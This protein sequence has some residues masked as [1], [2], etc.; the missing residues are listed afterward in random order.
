MSPRAIDGRSSFYTLAPHSSSTLSNKTVP[1]PLGAL[2]DSLRE[3]VDYTD[4]RCY[5]VRSRA[6]RDPDGHVQREFL[7]LL[8][9]VKHSFHLS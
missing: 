5:L 8:L 3:E 6:S 4:S 2:Y 9:Y 1:R 7:L